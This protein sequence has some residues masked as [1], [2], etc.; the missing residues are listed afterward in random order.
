MPKSS[1]DSRTPRSR[2]WCSSGDGAGRVGHD[3]ALGDL[4]GQP[5]GRD[6]VPAQQ[7]VDLVDQVGVVQAAGGEV[8]GDA[9]GRAR[10]AA[11]ARRR[12]SERVEDVGGQ[13]ADQPAALGDRDEL[14]G[15]DPAELGVLPAHQRLDAD[16]LPDSSRA[17]GCTCT[18]IVPFCSAA[19]SSETSV[20]RRGLWCRA[21][22]RRAAG[23]GVEVFASYI[24]RSARL[25][26]VGRRRSRAPGPG[27][28]PTEA[29]TST[30]RPS[31]AIGCSR[32]RSIR[33]P[34]RSDP[35]LV[36][37]RRARGRRTRRRRAGRR[38]RPRRPP[39][40]AGRRPRPAAGRRAG[41]RGCR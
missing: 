24:A 25:S 12:R 14:V 27:R 11:T 41:D 19:R 4:Q 34:I 35:P 37:G 38:C 33:R 21:R 1:T 32:A 30:S 26:R 5:L 20:S 31:R 40:P 16:H 22:A 15:G 13:R 36:G 28:C 39:R 6:V 29:P 18:W 9:R 2:S 3:R 10:P 8:D 7:A 23:R 17:W